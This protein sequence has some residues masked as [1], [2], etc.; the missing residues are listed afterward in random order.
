MSPSTTIHS[1]FEI[2]NCKKFIRL[3]IFSV[4]LTMRLI[5]QNK[6]WNFYCWK[7]EFSWIR[8]RW[9]FW[10][11]AAQLLVL[12]HRNCVASF[13]ARDTNHWNIETYIP[14]LFVLWYKK[15]V[16]FWQ[17]SKIWIGF[18]WYIVTVCKRIFPCHFLVKLRAEQVLRCLPFKIRK[19]SQSGI[20]FVFL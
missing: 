19:R 11:T 9:N 1:F 13:A 12:L 6:F 10:D 2:S 16:S 17:N 18:I 5:L 20:N 4:F 15:V 14:P 3:F 7:P 8:I